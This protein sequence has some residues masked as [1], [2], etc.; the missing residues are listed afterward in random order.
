MNSENKPQPKTSIQVFDFALGKLGNRFLTH[1][2]VFLR[3]RQTNYISRV[4]VR[5][6]LHAALHAVRA[7]AATNV[8]LE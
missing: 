3:Q 5:L 6:L 8:V 2:N 7:A 4:S 1:L